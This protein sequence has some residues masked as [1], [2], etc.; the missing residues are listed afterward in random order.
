[1]RYLVHLRAPGLDVIGMGEPSAP[2]ISMGHNGHA[3]FSM[4]LSYADQE[5]LYV[6]ETQEGEPGRYRYGDGWEALATVRGDLRG[7]GR[8]ARRGCP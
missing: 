1:M 4:T 2:G 6:Y 7:P 3:A 8:A 5:D